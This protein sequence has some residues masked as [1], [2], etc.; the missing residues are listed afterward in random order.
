MELTTGMYTY[1][2]QWSLQT[3]KDRYL[4]T[5]RTYW[6]LYPKVAP[7]TAGQHLQA[8]QIVLSNKFPLMKTIFTLLLK[9]LNYL[10]QCMDLS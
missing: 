10:E 8:Q 4:G 2:W 5:M 6:T 7:S 1:F 9:T 3:K